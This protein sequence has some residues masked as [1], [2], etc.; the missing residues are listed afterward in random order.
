MPTMSKT[1]KLL[2]CLFISYITGF[3]GSI[4]TSSSVETWYQTLEKPLMTPPG[5]VF[6]PVWSLL[7]TL[8]GIAAYLVWRHTTLLPRVR[9]A[10]TLFGAQLILNALWSFIFFGLQLTYLAF[11][12]LLLLWLVMV[13]TT[14]HFWKI[15]KPA[16]ILMMP[17][18]AWVL[19]ASYLNYGI[20]LLN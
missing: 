12:E 11:F 20:W 3:I 16:A 10:L 9:L 17:Y 1:L 7:Y 15:S 13:A 18:H 5:W 4:F 19:F 6:A 8:M 2:T 14:Y